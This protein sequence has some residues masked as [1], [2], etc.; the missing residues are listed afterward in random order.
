MW[1]SFLD[2]V[3]EFQIPV[4]LD[5]IRL[6]RSTLLYDTLAARLWPKMDYRAFRSYEKRAVRRR[7]RKIEKEVWR[8]ARQGVPMLI[9]QVAGVATLVERLKFYLSAFLRDA[10]TATLAMSSKVSYFFATI[11]K[12]VLVAVNVFL[13]GACLKVVYHQLNHDPSDNWIDDV[14]DVVAQL[15]DGAVSY[16]EYGLLLFCVLLAAIVLRRLLWRLDDPQRKD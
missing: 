6:L 10:P 11:T 2:V 9:T 1:L 5:T 3:R 15:G 16:F 4:N 8:T 13:I 12:A 14:T 7:A